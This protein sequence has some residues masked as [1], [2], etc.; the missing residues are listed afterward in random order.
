MKAYLDVSTWTIARRQPPTDG[1]LPDSFADRTRVL[2]GCYGL[3]IC[4]PDLPDDRDIGGWMKDLAI[5]FKRE[6]VTEV[7]RGPGRAKRVEP[8]AEL[9]CQEIG[10]EAG[11]MSAKEVI[12]RIEPIAHFRVTETTTRQALK[13]VAER[14]DAEKM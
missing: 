4:F 2:S 6:W 1:C 12:Q 10:S 14:F 5:V 8:L 9:I 7:G 11:K 13:I 3:S